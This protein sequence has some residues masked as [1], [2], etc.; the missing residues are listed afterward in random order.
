MGQLQFKKGD[1]IFR[2]GDYG[3]SF[4]QI[5]GGAVEIIANL[6][7]E[8]EEKLTQ[9]KK[10]QFFGEMAVIDAI[11]R[12]A[13][14]VA[15]E[16][17]TTVLEIPSGKFDQ[18][19]NE[20]PE[21]IRQVMIHL[22]TRLR[23]VTKDYQEVVDV[24]RE[25]CTGK[26]EKSETLLGKIKRFASRNKK[27]TSISAEALRETGAEE[28][29]GSYSG[30]TE[31][32][33]KGTVIFRQGE[34]GSCMYQIH[35]GTVGIYTDYGTNQ[36]KKLTALSENKFFGEIGM[37][38]S[39]PRSATAVALDDNT[40]VEIISQ[41]D[42]Q[43]LYEKNPPKFNMI[44]SHLSVRLRRLTKDYL[45]ACS[46]VYEAFEQEEKGQIIDETLLG[47]LKEFLDSHEV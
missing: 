2:E 9:L 31:T 34:T 4:Y 29:T 1:V 42:L 38:E 21:M 44:L 39:E 8:D 37:L 20:N 40:S 22:G 47:R 27:G 19:F 43:A 14:A 26:K 12:S 23:D 32:Y 24:I 5:T 33:K 46:L 18:F 6:G 28:N 11:P 13:S 17:D 10:D 16:D 15:L 30:K 41:Q 25:I 3:N 45:D 36:E 35:W 7:E